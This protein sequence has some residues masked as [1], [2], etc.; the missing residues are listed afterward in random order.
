M[1]PFESLRSV[2]L[3]AAAQENLVLAV[4]LRAD[5]CELFKDTGGV[6][7]ADP[8]LVPAARFLA[9]VDA[10]QLELLADLG[11]E[12]V[13]PV[14]VRRARRG[15]LRLVVRALEEDQPITEVRPGGRRHGTRGEADAAIGLMLAVDRKERIARISLVGPAARMPELL[16]I[17]AHGAGSFDSDGLRVVWADVPLDQAGP[18]A[19]AVHASLMAATP[20]GARSPG[21]L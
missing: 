15:R 12:V 6:M 13:H 1:E 9:S 11:S 17:P 18:A 7:E 4:A 3:A 2:G 5:R 19:R 16:P 14:A 21:E 10:R 8:H 20:A